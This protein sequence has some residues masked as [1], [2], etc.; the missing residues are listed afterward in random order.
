MSYSKQTFSVEEVLT[1]TKL[2]QV[3]DNIEFMI[4][5]LVSGRKMAHGAKQVTFNGT[6]SFA[7]AAVVFASD[8][9]DGDPSFTST[10]FILVQ[11]H[12]ASGDSGLSITGAI[13]TF[14]ADVYESNTGFTAQIDTFTAGG[15]VPANG[16]TLSVRW[17]AF[18]V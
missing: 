11:L 7:T 1:S 3:S 4:R 8:A 18:G 17:W 2:N 12:R 15:G 6:D 10:P 9:I 14:S 5:S 16:E 13:T